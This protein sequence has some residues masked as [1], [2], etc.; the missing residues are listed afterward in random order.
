MADPV[1][2]PT[3]E[4]PPLPAEL[5]EA[6]LRQ[7][8]DLLPHYIGVFAPDGSPLYLNL[9]MHGYYG[10]TIDEWSRFDF[11]HP[12]DREDFL[13]ERK[14]RFLDGQPHECEV[15]FLQHDGTYHWF[16]VR[17][18]PLKDARGDITR[19]CVTATDIEDRKRAE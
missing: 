5:Q 10:G 9:L 8:L 6:E 12:D 7:I 13:R 4:R 14:S 16:L 1:N 19:W 3:Q 11:V 15:R 18:N 17:R 2:S